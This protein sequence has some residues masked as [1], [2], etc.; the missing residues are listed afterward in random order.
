[1][2]SGEKGLA[3]N[4]IDS[5]RLKAILTDYLKGEG[6]G[7]PREIVDGLID[8]LRSRNF[9]L[10]YRGGDTYGFVHRTFLEYFCATEIVH[11][12]KEEQSLSIEQLRDDIFGQ[13]WQDKTWHE[14]LRLICGLL[15]PKWAGQLVEFLME[16][17][18]DRADYL[19]DDKRA[20]E[21][22]FQHLQLAIECFAEVRNPQSISSIA[23]KLKEK[24]KN[25]IQNQSRISITINN[26]A[27]NSLAKYYHTEPETLIWLKNFAALN[28]Q[29]IWVRQ[30]AV[31][32][33]AKYY[34][35]E[36]ETL[37]WLKNFAALNG[38]DRVVR[39]AAVKSVA[40]YYH[41]EPGTSTWVHNITKNWFEPSNPY[42]RT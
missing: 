4:L 5:R 8:Q 14:V 29:N 15:V 7:N 40:K 19:D 10:C 36:P 12:F 33:I 9:I 3:G 42:R 30:V 39:W 1:M 11:Q 21:E 32:S 24:L 26:G 22:A 6:F 31:E 27:V 20:K 35:D 16:R 28:G 37:I 23:A 41:I 18:V 13:H 25:E 17:E 2:Q 38:Q 34:T